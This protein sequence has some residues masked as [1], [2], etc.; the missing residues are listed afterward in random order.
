MLSINLEKVGELA[1]LQITEGDKNGFVNDL[2]R[3]LDMI[4]KLSELDV[5]NYTPLIHCSCV[6]NNF[7]SD[8]PHVPSDKYKVLQ[9]APFHD[10]DYFKVP[11]FVD[12][13]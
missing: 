5:D 8:D 2:L 10:G 3:I 11:K 6:S 7:R 13:Y 4:N 12:K 1:R 9:N